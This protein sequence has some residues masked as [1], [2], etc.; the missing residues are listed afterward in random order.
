LV[1]CLSSPSV[2]RLPATMTPPAAPPAEA[3]AD[4]DALASSTFCRL[5]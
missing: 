2:G 1:V 3:D 4:A 5:E